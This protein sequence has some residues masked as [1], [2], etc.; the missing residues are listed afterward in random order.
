MFA[1]NRRD[2]PAM[3]RV[4]SAARCCGFSKRPAAHGSIEARLLAPI[5][6]KLRLVAANSGIKEENITLSTPLRRPGGTFAAEI[7]LDSLDEVELAMD[8]EQEFNVRFFD[9]FARR[10]ETMF[11]LCVLIAKQQPS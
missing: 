7:G 9:D 8:I 5:F 1:L 4:Q 3:P 2:R 10:I 11:D 6:A